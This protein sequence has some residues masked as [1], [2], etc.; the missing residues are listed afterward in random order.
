MQT[1]DAHGARIPVIGFGTWRL[2]G[3]AC[4]TAVAEALRAG[5]RHIDT[6]AAYGNEDRVGEG[7]RAAGVPRDEVFV[8]TKVMPQ[9]LEDGALQR[10]LDRSLDQLGIGEVDL[11][12][13]HWPSRELPV[14]ETV[15][16]LNHARARGAARHI[17]VSNFTVPLLRAAWAAT[18]APLVTNQCEYHPYLSQDAV[19][20]ACRGWGMAFTA[21]SP[22]GRQ[23]VLDD[24]VIAAIAARHGRTAAQVVLRWDIQ[25]PGVV[26]IPKSATPERIRQN[27]DVFDF[28]L[29]ADEMA[30]ISALGDTH[31]RRLGNF[32]GLAPDW[33][34]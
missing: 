23:R 27:L 10:T 4:A 22:L 20:A 9:D 6:A 12:L 25:Q 32:G 15:A 2:S 30:A 14:A 18:D 24:P 17:G 16:S 1:V 13:I 11:V 34:D 21:Y 28:A 3:E 7:L 33:D 26:T 8:T 31:R 29:G 5:Y 19:I